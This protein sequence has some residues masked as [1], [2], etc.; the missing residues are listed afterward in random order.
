MLYDAWDE[1]SPESICKAYNKLKIHLDNS[2]ANSEPEQQHS[3]GSMV[4]MLQ[5]VQEVGNKD[6]LNALD[7]EDW[8]NLDNELPTMEQMS[9]KQILATVTGHSNE[10]ESSEEEDDGQ[11]ENK[12][13]IKRQQNVL[14]S[15]CPGWKDRTML[16][17]FK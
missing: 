6:P 3:A 9:D 8:L 15:T 10:N 7:L 17:L 13:P 4:E 1:A 2:Q 11:E 12:F 14:K 5:H 16:T